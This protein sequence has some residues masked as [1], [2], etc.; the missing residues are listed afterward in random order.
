MNYPRVWVE[1][2]NRARGI[3]QQEASKLIVLNLELV[4]LGE[5]ALPIGPMFEGDPSR[6]KPLLF[7][8]LQNLELIQ[9]K[10]ID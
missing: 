1:K 6:L 8:V 2:P 9:E 4:K 3:Q 5:E 10:H 7:H